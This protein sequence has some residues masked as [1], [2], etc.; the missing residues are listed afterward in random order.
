[1]QSRATAAA[2]SPNRELFRPAEIKETESLDVSERIKVVVPWPVA[3]GI[4][5]R[6]QFTET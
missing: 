5:V 3:Q 2:T 6:L 4:G 1:V